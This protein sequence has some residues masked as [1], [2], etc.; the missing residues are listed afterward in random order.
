MKLKYLL[1]ILTIFLFIGIASAQTFTPTEGNFAY[2]EVENI[3]LNGINFTIPTEYEQTFENDTEMHF[4]GLNT[5]K[6]SVNEYG[7]IE[8]VKSDPSKNITSEKTMFGS[9]EGY[10][11]DKNGTYTLSYKEDGK[12]I[13]IKSK[14]MPL[15]IGV[16]GKD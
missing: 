6:I 14:N 11:V 4:K 13:V 9:I 12:L 3:T 1:A 8:K 2:R 15:M 16:I 10:L 5:L 7:K